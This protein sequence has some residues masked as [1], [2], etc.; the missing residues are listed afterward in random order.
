MTKTGRKLVTILAMLC[1]VALTATGG[2]ADDPLPLAP[3][4]FESTP[5][6]IL[7][8]SAD[9]LSVAVQQH[10]EH[11]FAALYDGSVMMLDRTTRK[12]VRIVK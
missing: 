7:H 5:A 11:I 9:V 1:M 4:E 8:G 10:G 6:V 2:R 12:P 3:T